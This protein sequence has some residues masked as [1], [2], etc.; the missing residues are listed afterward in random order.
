MTFKTLCFL[1]LGATS[2]VV[3]HADTMPGPHPLSDSTVVESWDLENGLHVVTRHVPEA[4]AVAITVGYR[5]GT[6]DD[7][8]GLEGLAHVMGEL[9]F[10]SAVG[11]APERNREDL[12]SQRPLG[13]SFPVSRRSTLFTEIASLDQFPGVVSQVAARMRG[14]QVTAEG[15]SAAVTSARSELGEQLHGPVMGALY[16]QVREV[17]VATKDEDILRRASGRGLGALR[18]DEVSERI[19]RLYVPSNA[20]VSLAGNLRG[21]DVKALVTSLFG[22]I[23]PGTPSARGTRPKLAPGS[24]VMRLEG[25]REAG[26]AVGL[27]APALD[28]SLHP[29]FYLNALLLGSHFNRLWLREREGKAPNRYH[30]AVFDEPDL[31]RIFP[32]VNAGESDPAI[33]N[34]RVQQALGT[35]STLI[36]TTEPYNEL[37]SGVLWMLGGPMKP[38]LATRV[39]TD[40]ALLH[41]M[42]RTMAARAL[43]GGDS[44]WEDYRARFESEP[45]GN[46]GRW[47]AYF[48][49][50]QHQVLLLMLPKK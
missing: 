10:T 20:V 38:E 24:R 23:P 35:F 44:F 19:R 49:D 37:R 30:Y 41:T 26:G 8:E 15:L 4:R 27:I 48:G 1:L 31:L 50:P 43:W 39:R 16:H 45:P 22:A 6:D 21:L 33:L 17:A 2:S 5:I 36:V 47:L 7:P 9:V 3:A 11:D 18:P 46:L 34:T 12:D 42:A 32:P 13:W 40:P 29:S 28:D 14:V 25:I